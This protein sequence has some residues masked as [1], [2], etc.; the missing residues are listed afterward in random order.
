MWL[1]RERKNRKPKRR[2]GKRVQLATRITYL[3]NENKIDTPSKLYLRVMVYQ[4]TRKY[5]TAKGC[6]KFARNVIKLEEYEIYELYELSGYNAYDYT[7]NKLTDKFHTDIAQLVWYNTHN[8]S[9]DTIQNKFNDANTP[10]PACLK[11]TKV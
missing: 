6:L 3:L 1:Y 9:S 11:H 5:I 2:N 10:L 7:P 4:K 8:L